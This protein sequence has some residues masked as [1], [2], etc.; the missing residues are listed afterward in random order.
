VVTVLADGDVL[1]AGGI[2]EDGS[3]AEYVASAD[4]VLWQ[5]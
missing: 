3:R 2:V 1:I 4:A 5:P